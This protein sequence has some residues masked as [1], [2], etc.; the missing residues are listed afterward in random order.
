MTIRT[1]STKRTKK[2]PEPIIVVGFLIII[3]TFKHLIFQETNKSESDTSNKQNV[4][5]PKHPPRA[6]T[7]RIPSKYIKSIRTETH[8][9]EQPFTSL[10][11]KIFAF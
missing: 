1:L 7:H 4:S 6:N 9:F 3:K 10:H 5:S 2:L 8:F 11:L